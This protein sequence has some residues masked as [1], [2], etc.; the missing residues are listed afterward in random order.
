MATSYTGSER[1]TR[2][3]VAVLKRAYDRENHRVYKPWVT[4]PGG[5]GALTT[6]HSRTP[7]APDC[8]VAMTVC[9]LAGDRHVHL[10]GGPCPV[11]WSL[12]AVQN[13][14][15]DVARQSS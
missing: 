6:A 3:V 15:P 8:L 10:G 2:R 11:R 1:T 4:E 13:C 9:C 7:S 14:R 5:V 12:S